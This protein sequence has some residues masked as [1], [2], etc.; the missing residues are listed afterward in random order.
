MTKPK[1][2]IIFTNERTFEA[3]CNKCDIDPC[4]FTRRW[5]LNLEKSLKS[6]HGIYFK[7]VN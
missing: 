6:H 4:K 2:K 5:C 7:K 1:Y 3:T